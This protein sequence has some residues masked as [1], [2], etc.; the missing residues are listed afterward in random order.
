MD[1]SRWGGE[2]RRGFETCTGADGSTRGRTGPPQSQWEA[3]TTRAVLSH[4][5]RSQKDGTNVT[6]AQGVDNAGGVPSLGLARASWPTPSAPPARP[7]RSRTHTHTPT[8]RCS[9]WGVQEHTRHLHL[10]STSVPRVT[11][12][13]RAA[14]ARQHATAEAPS[15]THPPRLGT[16][17]GPTAAHAAGG[18][19][20]PVP[21][22]QIL[23][24]LAQTEGRLLGQRRPGGGVAEGARAVGAFPP[25]PRPPPL[26]FA[27]F[28]L[29]RVPREASYRPVFS[30]G[31]V[32]RPHVGRVSTSPVVRPERSANNRPTVRATNSLRP[33]GSQELSKTQTPMGGQP[34][35][36]RSGGT[37][38]RFR[39]RPPA[40]AVCR[41]RF[42][43]GLIG[44]RPRAAQYGVCRDD[45]TGP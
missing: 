6:S 1:Q 41:R 36:S 12:L 20:R 10:S 42:Q 39:A 8:H 37:G 24:T 13:P 34:S 32:A 22:A 15:C 38:Q 23:S 30:Y 44:V 27:S 11:T 2:S 33:M 26:F 19:A 4:G 25:N 35:A 43:A 18:R 9:G 3:R 17:A 28:C 40:C 14:R 29:A 16:R 5:H 31:P 21:R 7:G 45:F